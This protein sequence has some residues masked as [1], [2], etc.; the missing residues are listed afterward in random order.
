MNTLRTSTE[1][2]L[3]LLGE[4]AKASPLDR[5]VILFSGDG[6]TLRGGIARGL[7]FVEDVSS[8]LAVRVL[9]PTPGSVTL[10]CCAAPGGKSFSCAID[11]ENAERY[12]PSTS[13]KTS[14]RLS[15]RAPSASA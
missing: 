8:R 7:W 13:T 10:D 5:D 2:C 1:E 3:A 9:A 12:T 4:H 6:E 14:F 11:M 15:A